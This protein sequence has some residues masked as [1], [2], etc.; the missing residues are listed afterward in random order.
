MTIILYGHPL[1]GN[2]HK[3]RLLLSALERSHE[4]RIVDVTKGEH[5]ALPFTAL[6]P[7]AQLPTLVDG[8]TIVYDA[9][10]ILVYLARKYDRDHEW[11]PEE[12]A[13]MARVVGWLSFAANEIQN[14]AHFARLHYLLGVPVAL[15]SA[16]AQARHAL[17]LLNDHLTKRSYLELE[18]PTIADLAC[19]PCVALAPEG[20]I[21]LAP[22]DHVRAW[23]DRI[24]AL[25]FFVPM[26]GM[27]KR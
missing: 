21:D 23:I 11:M 12:P 26:A 15:E 6:N 19:A 27:P 14:S 7:R 17:D 22:Y 3:V 5:K 1:S 9:Q 2:T 25:P 10:A 18:R 4:E 13:A 16:Q 8:E 20:K 24:R